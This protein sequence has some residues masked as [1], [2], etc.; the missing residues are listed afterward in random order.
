MG[1]NWEEAM[2]EETHWLELQFCGIMQ[3]QRLVYLGLVL[4]L[5]YGHSL[6]MQHPA[7]GSNSLLGSINLADNWLPLTEK[8]N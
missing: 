4:A 5:W 8:L 2:S 1:E 3:V 6:P 7:P